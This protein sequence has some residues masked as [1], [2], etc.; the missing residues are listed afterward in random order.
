MS[1]KNLSIAIVFMLGMNF[2][3]SAQSYIVSPTKLY[4]SASL[5]AKPLGVLVRGAWVKEVEESKIDGKF[6]KIIVD[7]TTVGFVLKSLLKKRLS[8]YDTYDEKGSSPVIE[9]D[10]HYG[11][12]HMFITVASLRGRTKPSIKAKVGKVFTMG[13]VV[14]V[15]YYPFNPD[16]WVNVDNYFVQQ[17]YLGKRPILHE[18]YQQFDSIPIS[19]LKERKKIG[20]RIG[21]FV[22]RTGIDTPKNPGLR[23]YLSVAKQLK[24]KQLIEKLVLEIEIEKA[25]TK[26]QFTY[27][28]LQKIDKEK[29]Y[30]LLNGVRLKGYELSLAELL[31]IKGKPIRKIKQEEDCCYSGN[32]RY[33]YNDGEF[34][35][36]ETKGVVE[37]DWFS[38]KTNSYVVN[39]FEISSKVIRS[40]F[41][42][43]LASIFYYNGL[44]PNSYDFVNFLDYATIGINFKKNKPNT[45]HFFISP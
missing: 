21:E 36:E 35:V 26:K 23:R 9:N 2:F 14:R 41:V 38:L 13:E 37:I 33:I 24:D 22:W 8:I 34:I 40:E 44:Y 15:N 12:A 32:M 30:I 11:A 27:E 39:G 1:T 19:D 42:K 45:F 3:I 28:E 25:K 5:K 18:L 17:K 31:S 20:Q 43:N 29:N 4:E 16:E 10:G 6:Q 7:N